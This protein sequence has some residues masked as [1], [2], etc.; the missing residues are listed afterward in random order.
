M[1]KTERMNRL[2]QDALILKAEICHSVTNLVWGEGSLDSSLAIVGESPA[3]EEDL[4]GRPFVGQAGRYLNK[5]L[6]T[7]G[8]VRDNAYVTNVVKCR[9]IRIKDR[10]LINRPPLK[11]EV[12]TWANILLREL[13]IVRPEIVLCLGNASASVLIKRPFEMTKHRGEWFAGPYGERVIATFHPA[14]VARFGGMNEGL[15]QQKFRRDLKTVAAEL[16]SLI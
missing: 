5:E 13:E 3:S 12:L 16:K 6:E 10:K 9:P 1:N 2:R 15:V 7:A 11:K 4:S 14:Y 8:I